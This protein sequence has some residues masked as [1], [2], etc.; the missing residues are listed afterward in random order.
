MPGGNSKFCS[1]IYMRTFD[2][3]GYGSNWSSWVC[4]IFKP[5][6]KQLFFA[7]DARQLRFYA[8]LYQ[9]SDGLLSDGLL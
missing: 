1:E 5:V 6:P 2:N 8:F 9:P 4:F 3:F 7:S